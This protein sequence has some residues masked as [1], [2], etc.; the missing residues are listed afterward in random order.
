MLLSVDFCHSH[1]SGVAPCQEHHS[2]RSHPSNQIDCLLSEFLP[3]LIG[4]A[5]RL[6]GTDREAGIEHQN[7]PIG[8]RSEKTSIIRR[9][10]EVWVVLLDSSVDVDQRWRSS[11]RR[12]HRER[13][14]MS[15]IIIVIRVLANHDYFDSVQG[16]VSGPGYLSTQNRNGQLGTGL[17]RIDIL[18]RRKDLGFGILFFLEE[19]LQVQELSSHHLILE[20]SKPAL[21]QSI[22]LQLEQ[23]L[24]LRRERR[25]P[26]VLVKRS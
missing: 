18:F 11:S 26:F 7:T 15:L 21:V 2:V 25:H 4:V 17:P 5:I 1:S 20:I 14:A 12:S 3:S 22:D 19:A 16:R 10:L 13:Q 6:M 9:Y 23:L 8:P 24:L